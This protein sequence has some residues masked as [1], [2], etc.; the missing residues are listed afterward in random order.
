MAPVTEALL[1]ISFGEGPHWDVEEQAL[2]YCNFTDN[3][4]NKYN[5]LTRENTCAEF[6]EHV[7]FIIPI[8]GKKHHFLGGMRRDIVEIEWNGEN[9]TA[10][11][12]RIVAQVDDDKPINVLNDGKADP[13]GRLYTGTLGYKPSETIVIEN[14][15]HEN[16]S[17]YRLDVDNQIHKLDAVTLANGLAWDIER[18][19][20]YYVDSMD[21]IRRYDYDIETGNISNCKKIFVAAEHGLKGL[22][23]GMTIDTDGNLWVA[24]FE[25]SKVVKIEGETGKLLQK[26]TIPTSEV[27]SVAFGGSNLDILYVTSGNTRCKKHQAVWGAALYEVTGLGVKRYAPN[28]VKIN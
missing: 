28:K 11:V 7:S 12:V 13:R 22:C 14:F 26:V 18:K 2:Y 21:A 24:V 27:T 10:R 17:L 8:E 19:Y 15:I 1:T 25:A 6:D 5:P 3:T 23:D 20:F 4:I 9:D 16:G